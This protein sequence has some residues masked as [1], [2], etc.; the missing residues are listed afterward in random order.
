MKMVERSKTKDHPV[1]WGLIVPQGWHS[2]FP[3]TMGSVEQAEFMINAGKNAE[4]A[5]FDSIW[6]IDHLEP[7]PDK[8]TEDSVF[9]CWTSL[10]AL[11]RETKT[12]RLGQAVT[13]VCFRNPALLAKMAATVDV[14]SGGRLD[15]GIGAGWY[16]N[17]FS[18]YGYEFGSPKTR[19]NKMR[20]GIEI[21]KG[22]WTKESVTYE[23]THYQVNNAYSYP[24]PLQKPHPPIMIGGA[25]E[26]VTLRIVAEHANRSNF[27]ELPDIFEKKLR[28]LEN[29]CKAVGRDYDSIEKS[30][31]RNFI[32]GKTS[33]DADKKMKKV[34]FP[35]DTIENFRFFNTWGTPEDLINHF[36]EYRAL[37]VSYFM[38]YLANIANNPD[39]IQFFADEIIPGVN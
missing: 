26:K 16:D 28:I 3:K 8:T 25:G 36:K 38:V 4:K 31:F 7:I 14:L 15:L 22:L 17:E 2:E 6:T 11:A 5:G 1:R 33:A 18:A 35:G 34:F 27:Q 23:G 19:L 29:H 20:E 32:V 13:C 37:G 30:Y 24:K 9:E 21:I 12:I 39:D 10:A